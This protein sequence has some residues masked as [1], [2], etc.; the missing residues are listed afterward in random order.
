MENRNAT[1]HIKTPNATIDVTHLATMF[2]NGCSLSRM[3]KEFLSD[4]SLKGEMHRILR[5]A[6]RENPA[7]FNN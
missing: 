6:I 7:L 4:E 5:K 2:H 3:A 1:T